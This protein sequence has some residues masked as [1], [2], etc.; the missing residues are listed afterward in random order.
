MFIWFLNIEVRCH[1]RK[2]QR[3]FG[4]MIQAQRQIDQQSWEYFLKLKSDASD[5]RSESK[6]L[7]REESEFM[8]FHVKGTF[9]EDFIDNEHVD[10]M[11]THSSSIIMLNEPVPSSRPYP[12]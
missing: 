4:F 9:V 6:N 2:L 5:T 10:N 7:K 8:G 1:A 11:L 3:P 12:Y